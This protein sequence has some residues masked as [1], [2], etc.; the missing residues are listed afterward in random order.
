[1]LFRAVPTP[2][3]GICSTTFGDTVCRGCRRYLH[4]V[5]NW[6][7]Y[8]DNEKRLIWQRLDG[9]T[10]QVLPRYFDILSDDRLTNGLRRLRIPF[11]ED[12]S[13]WIRLATLLKQTARQSPDL[14]EFG[15][16]RLDLSGLSLADLRE[17]MV[18]E[19]AVLAGK[20]IEIDIL[21]R[22]RQPDI[23]ARAVVV[24]AFGAEIDVEIACRRGGGAGVDTA[25]PR[26]PSAGA[27][28]WPKISTHATTPLKTMVRPIT[29]SGAW[30]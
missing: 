27:P 20:A 15:V 26:R 10:A 21:A 18:V 8:S 4:E 28:K 23:V 1:M 22:S 30:K 3:V 14:A 11:R 6:N 24:E 29:I 2:C 17:Q 13:P 5:I 16:Q 12:A 25:E 19:R 9:L 7:R